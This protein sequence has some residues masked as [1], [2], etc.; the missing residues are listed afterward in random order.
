MLI[1]SQNVIRQLREEYALEYVDG[2][3]DV[4]AR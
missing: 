4:V 3:E 2:A 1:M